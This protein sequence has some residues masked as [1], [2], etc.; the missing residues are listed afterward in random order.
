VLSIVIP[1]LNAALGLRR[2]LDGIAGVS[3]DLPCEVIVADG[4][5]VDDTHLIAADCGAI[6]LETRRG[7]GWQLGEGAK[8]AAGDW[9]LFLHGDTVPGDGWALTVSAFM[10][11]PINRRRAGYFRF[12]LDDDA[13]GARWLERIVAFRS[14]FMGLPYG[15]QGLLISRVLYEDLG[16]FKTLPLMEDV[17]LVRRIGRGRLAALEAVAVTSAERYRREGYLWRPLRNAFCLGLY[18]AGVPPK[19]IDPLYR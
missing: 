6:F 8:A 13:S 15:D 11:D 10:A 4:G 7:R 17:D 16:G 18:S 19:Y 12:A 1:T 9:F 14:R 2:T 5:S 3:D